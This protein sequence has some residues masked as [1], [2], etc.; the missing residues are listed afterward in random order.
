MR[1]RLFY[2]LPQSARRIFADAA[3]VEFAAIMSY[4]VGDTG[5]RTRPWASLSVDSKRQWIVPN[6]QAY[7]TQAAK[8]HPSWAP[9]IQAYGMTDLMSP[10]PPLELEPEHV[11]VLGF[12]CKAFQGMA[13][14]GCWK[15]EGL[16][17]PGA[18]P[19]AAATGQAKRESSGAVV[20]K[21]PAPGTGANPSSPPALHVPVVKKE[22]VPRSSESR[23]AGD[24]SESKRPRR[25]VTGKEMENLLTKGCDVR[26]IGPEMLSF[27][28]VLRGLVEMAKALFWDDEW[29][30]KVA[31]VNCGDEARSELL[32]IQF[33]AKVLLGVVYSS[34]HYA[35]LAVDKRT[36]P[37]CCFYDGM[38]DQQC[39]DHA[40]AFLDYL[41]QQE[42]IGP[43][44][45]LRKAQV[46][47]QD[48]GWS[49]G[50]RAIL[51]ANLVLEA[52]A[53]NAE[54]PVHVD[55]MEINSE[56]IKVLMELMTPAGIQG[57]RR[58]S[59]QASSASSAAPPAPVTPPPRKRNTDALQNAFSP[60]A[61]SEKS[62][63]RAIVSRADGSRQHAGKT[64]SE[65]KT[66]SKR[67]QK[68]RKQDLG[69]KA[70]AQGVT[71]RRFQKDHYAE[72]I[73]PPGGH[74]QTFLDSLGHE[75]PSKLACPVCLGLRRIALNL[76]AASSDAL[77]PVQDE[78]LPVLGA[79]SKRKGR[80]RKDEDQNSR[81]RLHTFV[82]LE[83]SNIYLQTKDSYTPGKFVYRCVPCDRNIVFGSQTDPAKIHRHERGKFHQAGLGRLGLASQDKEMLVEARAEE[84]DTPLAQLVPLDGGDCRGIRWDDP[85]RPPHSYKESIENWF[86]AG[87]PC[88]LYSEKE[89]D[90]MADVSFRLEGGAILVISSKCLKTCSRSEGACAECRKA[91]TR[92]ELWKQVCKMSFLVDLA[93]LSF[94]MAYR[95]EKQVKEH[96]DVMKQRDY[97]KRGVCGQDID[98]YVKQESMV[99]NV[100][101]IVHKFHCIPAWRLSPA[102]KTLIGT[103]LVRTPTH[104]SGD[105]E[106]AAHACLVEQLSDAV[107]TGKVH[108]ADLALGAK[109]AAGKLRGDSIVHGLVS[110]FLDM[111]REDL[112]Q[113]RYKTTS[114][115]LRFASVQEALVDLGQSQEVKSL[116]ARFC[117]NTRKLP[118]LSVWSELLPQP[119]LSL[120]DPEK[121]GNSI[122]TAFGHLKLGADRA[123]L[124]FDETV[125][126]PNF[127]LMIGG[128][129]GGGDIIV[130]GQWSR[131]AADNF[132]SLDPSVHPLNTLPQDKVSRLCLSFLFK[133]TDSNKWAMDVCQLPR[134]RGQANAQEMLFM[135]CSIL[136]AATKEQ[137]GVPPLGTACDAATCN[138]L[139]AKA[140]AGQLPPETLQSHSFLR[141]CEVTYPKFA[142]WPFGFVRYGPNKHLMLGFLG[143]F[144]LQKRLSLQP[145]SGSKKIVLGNLYVETSF[146]LRHG[147]PAAAYMVRDPMCDRHSSCRLAPCYIGRSWSG[148]GNHVFCL[149]GALLS[150]ITTASACF[151]TSERAFN[152]FTL[153]YLGL[154]HCCVNRRRFGGSWE[155]RSI[156]LV[157]LRN[158]SIT[159]AAA[160]ASCTTSYEPVAL[161]ELR[162]EHHFGAIKSHTPG[163]AGVRD[164]L[165]GTAKE[166]A[167]QCC[168]LRDL[169]VDELTTPFTTQSREPLS[170]EQLAT[171]AKQALATSLQFFACISVDTTPN[172]LYDQLR[173]WWDRG[174]GA[175]LFGC[176]KP[177]GTVE[178]EDNN[179]GVAGELIPDMIE[180]TEE[181]AS[182]ESGGPSNTF[183]GMIA[184][185][186]NRAAASEELHAALEKLSDPAQ[187]T[188]ND[189]LENDNLQK[190]REYFLSQFPEE[191]D[192][193]SEKDGNAPVPK[194]LLQLL[195]RALRHG[196]V[197]FDLGEPGSL[198]EQACLRRAHALVGGVRRL[199]RLCRLEEGLLAQAVLERSQVPL[200]EHN[201][202]QHQLSLARQAAGLNNMRMARSEAWTRAQ[203]AFVQTLQKSGCCDGL[204]PVKSYRPPGEEEEGQIVLFKDAADDK[205]KLGLIIS[206][207]RV[208]PGSSCQ[209][210]ACMTCLFH[211]PCLFLLST[212]L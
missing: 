173:T 167:R 204:S 117:V 133:R 102:L 7:L 147:L 119:F 37:T 67:E 193:E 182:G 49:C 39:T 157:T 120:Q 95:D 47:R 70:E 44:C 201:L 28:Q 25:A 100:R 77:V 61:T 23:E 14:V 54:L 184:A 212:V 84:E 140:F 104:H 178:P 80:P 10:A 46:P 134:P 3:L 96:V 87:Q 191:P 171:C 112:K 22:P 211:F 111:Y 6:H 68:R 58:S 203:S 71:H 106:S 53:S 90:P 13:W 155:T 34:T 59:E 30:G 36:Q 81:W 40:V 42:W 73:Q 151:S 189:T 209:L 202:R 72:N 2:A 64:A 180:V 138:K 99:E 188:G 1:E 159:C 207:A 122:R 113:Q 198:G 150:A 152:A 32:G 63:P 57:R 166:H 149:W 146:M 205:L 165:L 74:W 17:V 142:L 135:V 199:S 62:T 83:R 45:P 9:Y 103:Y 145:Q 15:D 127:E 85:T 66:E 139:V 118:K 208:Q 88:M 121:L 93:A 75:G 48:D 174:G 179:E 76:G 41:K 185:V 101:T 175:S 35:L 65:P 109:V 141:Q 56:Q 170:A 89:Q 156:A 132:A 82:R 4:H 8:D 105:V 60:E 16:P 24:Q 144:H 148:L 18:E 197:E 131:V 21:E 130:G 162:I 176:P 115:F 164:L 51:T 19:A 137:A 29:V 20:K 161:Q 50:H 177:D 154:L 190:A 163:T 172:D 116:L 107:R 52:V 200:N 160:V 123:F 86:Y 168:L 124:L 98:T 33:D 97:T 69:A 194:T 11:A 181:A 206:A 196:S 94:K 158:I 5:M 187:T 114:A 126:A 128:G 136:E 129:P 143:G 79:P 12:L 31:I 26:P 43:V 183:E 110:S 192:G 195:Q 186:E 169:S 108:S 91:A 78:P 38:Q 210:F 55:D 92:K 125:V 27:A 153:H